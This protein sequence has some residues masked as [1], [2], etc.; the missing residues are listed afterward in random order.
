MNCPLCFFDLWVKNARSQKGR[1]VPV[2]SMLKSR[3]CGFVSA[4][5]DDQGSFFH[6]FA[7]VFLSYAKFVGLTARYSARVVAI[8]RRASCSL[9]FGCPFCAS[10]SAANSSLSTR[11]LS[12]S[13]SSKRLVL[14]ASKAL[15]SSAHCFH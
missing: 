13:Q 4:A 8:S 3:S 2:A 10:H 7:V 15:W 5:M 11:A 12:V 1:M 6:F 9:I 14:K